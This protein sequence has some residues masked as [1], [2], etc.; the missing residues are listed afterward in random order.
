MVQSRPGKGGTKVKKLF[1]N[2]WGIGLVFSIAKLAMKMRYL[3]KWNYTMAAVP[4]GRRVD[5]YFWQV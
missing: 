3:G 1:I 2:I 5:T 4:H